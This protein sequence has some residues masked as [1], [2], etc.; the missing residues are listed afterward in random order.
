MYSLWYTFIDSQFTFGMYELRNF[1]SKLFQDPDPLS[2][3][4]CQD[5]EGK[6]CVPA[7]QTPPPT[8]E[9]FQPVKNTLSLPLDGSPSHSGIGMNAD[10][11]L[12]LT[13]RK[14]V[15]LSLLS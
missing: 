14:K 8:F 3:E 7:F 12:P 10:L 13:P 9:T 15:K 2:L 11:L 4:I 1:Y 6:V 5:F